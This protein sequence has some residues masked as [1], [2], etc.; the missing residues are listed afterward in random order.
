MVSTKLIISPEKFPWPVT[1][2][3]HSE[4][5]SLQFAIYPDAIFLF[6]VYTRRECAKGMNTL[7]HRAIPYARGFSP[8]RAKSESLQYYLP[9][10]DGSAVVGD[11]VEIYSCHS[12]RE[13]DGIGIAVCG[14]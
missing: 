6:E 14:S 3:K 11:A 13:I 5:A 7:N 4:V 1:G 2:A 10:L 9:L 8:F 12:A